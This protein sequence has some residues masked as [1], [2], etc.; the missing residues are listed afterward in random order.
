MGGLTRPVQDMPEFVS[1]ALDLRG[2]RE[3]YDVRPPYQRNDYL[4]WINRA[5]REDTK[6]GRL[7][8]MLRELEAGTGYMGMEW[9][10]KA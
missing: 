4:G 8:V 5:K 6:K 7:A 3:A 1:A 9:R 2:L 10:P